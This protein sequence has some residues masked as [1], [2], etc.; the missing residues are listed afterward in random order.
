VRFLLATVVAAV[1]MVGLMPTIALSAHAQPEQPQ[2]RLEVTKVTPS[3]VGGDA[4]GELTVSG[5]LTNPGS[6]AI[7]NVEAVVERGS[8]TTNEASVHSAL[9]GDASGTGEPGFRPLTDVLEPGQQTP[10]EVRIPING[11]SSLQITRPGVYPVLVHVRGEPSSGGRTRSL[12]EARFLLPVLSPPGTG[13]PRPPAP[14]PTTLLVPIV[15][16]PHIEQTPVRQPA[17]L[18]DDE[19]SA[20]LAPGGRL[21]ELVRAIDDGAGRGSPLGNSVCFAI[22]PDLLET[23]NAMQ[24]RYEVRQ[25]DGSHQPGSGSGAALLWLSKLTDVT[26]GRCVIALP[27][28]DV[29]VVALGRARLPDMI[30][31]SLKDG[32]DIVE[33]MLGVTPRRDMYWP[34]DGV[35][36]QTAASDLAAHGVRTVLTQPSALTTPKGSLA[37]VRTRNA[38][39]AKALTALP[40]DPLV[41]STLDPVREDTGRSTDVSPSPDAAPLSAQNALGALV[42][43]A[44]TGFQPNTTS[45][46]AP[47]RRWN[48]GGDDL[49]MMLAGMQQLQT[50]GYLQLSGLPADPGPQPSPADNALPRA[51][52]AYPVASV[53]NEI[54]PPQIDEL[55]QQNFKVRSLFLSSEKHFETNVERAE[56]TTPL[57]NAL[58]RSASS[59]WRGNVDLSLAWLHNAE[60]TLS[61]T[62]S[63]VSVESPWDGPVTL[64]EST[65][66]IP[67]TVTN[68]LPVTV[69]IVVRAA[70]QPGI[71]TRDL[72]EL[73]I[74]PGQR[75]FWME[76]DV[77]RTGQ[78][79]VDVTAVTSD[80]GIEL[81]TTKRLRLEYFAFGSV[82]TPLTI[83]AAALLVVLSARRIVRRVRKSRAQSADPVAPSV[84][85]PAVGISTTESDR[86]SN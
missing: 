85:E 29:D 61:A 69:K 83:I 62:L 14:T 25:R 27:Y 79:N 44:T 3:L 78:F 39:P 26:R 16:R 63:S 71:K 19:L 54:P 81:G 47:P 37:P 31:D 15:D 20:S 60:T 33:R 4:P 24:R 56:L 49:R 22:D 38:D 70:P 41:S 52:L 58:L 84:T 43:R 5:R 35:L 32:G 2:I 23:V 46:V 80:G 6:R 67:L 17:I 66:P 9:Q 30:E 40:I 74:P 1:L 75:T 36:D 11:P 76:T 65:S 7:N 51:D 45:V 57:R 21:F 13:V 12:G 86:N 72:G 28:A 10:F 68:G 42:F 73:K 59:A 48:L 64:G 50:A 55:A 77:G 34:I 8:A 53:P 18:A 82:I